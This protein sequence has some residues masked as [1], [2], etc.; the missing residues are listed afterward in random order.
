[1]ATTP[2]KSPAAAKA[3]E[4]DLVKLIV[5]CPTGRRFRAG[6]EFGATP[7]EAEVTDEQVEQLKADPCLAVSVA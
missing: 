3:A 4:S 6:L 5:A 1:M 7:I 2:R